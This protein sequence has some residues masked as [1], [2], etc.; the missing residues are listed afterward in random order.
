MEAEDLVLNDS[1][2]WKHVEEIGEVLPDIGVSVLPQA[3]VVKTIDLG[4][5]PTLVVS[6]QNSDSVL[7]AY[8]QTD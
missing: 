2:K 5:L 1:C 3:F 8:L 4:D 7:E 6:S